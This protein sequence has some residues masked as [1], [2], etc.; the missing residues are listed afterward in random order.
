VDSGDAVRA[1]LSSLVG[2]C[3]GEALSQLRA[4]ATSR[5]RRDAAVAPSKL[6]SAAAEFIHT[7]V[8]RV[9]ASPTVDADTVVDLARTVVASAGDVLAAAKSVASAGERRG[10]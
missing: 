3:Q 7:Y 4:L 10:S 9:L 5:D 1:L 8:R 2:V 6:A